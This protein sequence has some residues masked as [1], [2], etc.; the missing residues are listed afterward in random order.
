MDWPAYGTTVRLAAKHAEK[1][2]K[3]FQDSLDAGD[4]VRAWNETHIHDATTTPQLARDWAKVHILF[5]KK[6]LEDALRFLYSDGYVLGR[7]AGEYMVKEFVSNKAASA[8]VSVVNWDTWKPGNQAAS[9]LLE[10]KGSLKTLLDNRNIMVQGI[11]DTKLN[12]IG[13]ILSQSL[14][15]GLSTSETASLISGVIDDPERADIIAKTE[16]S[17]AVSVSSRE[18]YQD[19]GV[20]Q[21]EWLVAEGCPDCQDNAD[22]SPIDI[23]TEFPS[24]DTEPPAHPNC[25]CSLA[26][27]EIDNSAYE[28]STNSDQSDITGE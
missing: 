8:D 24:G 27:A 10:P 7:T 18:M 17:R 25:M 11:S 14:N 6:P 12:T 20:T 26:P 3:A 4:I 15:D 28:D 9:A 16:M 22:A 19:S 13:S 23:G 21:V 5:K 2:R 1:I